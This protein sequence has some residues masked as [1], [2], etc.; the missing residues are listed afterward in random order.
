MLSNIS[1]NIQTRYFPWTS[2]PSHRT[3]SPSDEGIISKAPTIMGLQTTICMDFKT[4]IISKCTIND[5][6]VSK[7]HHAAIYVGVKPFHA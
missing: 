5:H 7:G 3:P 6:I 4:Q 2:I 1:Y